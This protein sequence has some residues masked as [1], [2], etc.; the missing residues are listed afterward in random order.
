MQR[1]EKLVHTDETIY[2]FLPDEKQNLLQKLSILSPKDSSTWH[3]WVTWE[4]GDNKNRNIIVKDKELREVDVFMEGLMSKL[5]FVHMNIC[6]FSSSSS[7]YTHLYCFHL[8]YLLPPPPPPTCSLDR[9]DLGTVLVLV[10]VHI[11]IFLVFVDWFNFEG[12]SFCWLPIL[13]S[14]RSKPRNL[15]ID[16]THSSGRSRIGLN[17]FFYKI[18]W[19]HNLLILPGKTKENKII[20]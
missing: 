7:F 2:V 1:R 18:S 16:L 19:N 14:P 12:D 4:I 17:N 15:S 13:Y 20:A 9:P 3:N 5:V 11:E 6:L 10:T 8:W